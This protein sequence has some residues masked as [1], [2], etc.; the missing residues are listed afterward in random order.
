MKA[1]PLIQF[2]SYFLGAVLLL[3]LGVA[4]PVHFRSVSI[5]VLESAGRGSVQVQDKADEF[6]DVGAVGLVRIL[7][8]GVPNPAP[9]QDSVQRYRQ[10]M[11][12]RPVFALS[13]G[14]S[15]HFEALLGI[16]QPVAAPLPV[17]QLMLPAPRREAT[18]SY[19][20][21][22]PNTRVQALL[23]AR[24]L[25]G[26]SHFM[27]VFS[28]SGHPLDAA[29]QL[30]A[31]LEQSGA[32]RGDLARQWQPLVQA[33]A[34]GDVAALR[35]L[36][37]RL[38]AVVTIGMRARWAEMAAL[39]NLLPDAE[40]L[41]QFAHLVSTEPQRFAELAA[42]LLLARDA[43]ALLTYLYQN[44]E[45]GWQALPHALRF[46]Q[47]AVEHL[48]Q[49]NQPLYEL[50]P[51][52][53]AAGEPFIALQR[54]FQD[55]VRSAPGLALGLKNLLFLAAGWLLAHCALLV[56]QWMAAVRPGL[57][58]PIWLRGS[59]AGS[60]AL[61]GFGLVWVLI[62]PRLLEFETG[63]RAMPVLDLA[64]LHSHAN[65]SSSTAPAMFDQVTLIVLLMFF[66][67]Q[68]MVFMFCLVR[69]REVKT[70]PN[71]ADTKLKLL[72][73]EENLF[74]LGL[75]VGLGGT[76]GSLIM[77]VLN[78]VEASLMAAYAS[79]LFGILFVAIFK[80]GILRPYRRLLILEIQGVGVQ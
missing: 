47:G 44:G 7:W 6:L 57:H 66:V 36:E 54:V 33:A 18:L 20:L 80:V 34:E 17:M 12:Q 2:I 8:E 49:L 79:T 39:V 29:L 65:L 21:Q 68:L 77:I 40:S 52:L 48:T 3:S 28:S 50:P 56:F 41:Q 32:W 59:T 25:S 61:V 10:L 60:M 46:G 37:E 13:G 70:T 73:N 55:F 64:S 71:S 58:A 31:L 43:P 11:Q 16:W 69:L 72:D 1:A 4:V 26:W 23:R 9:A 53:R 15:A 14:P 51:L 67:V 76:V 22:S 74:D 42:G 24:E 63:A 78:I 75:Y 5:L 45:Q 27:P 35:N 38:T 19:L 30:T 62:E